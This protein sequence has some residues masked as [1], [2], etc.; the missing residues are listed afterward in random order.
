MNHRLHS[1]VPA[2]CVL[3]VATCLTVAPS[4]SG[5]ETGATAAVEWPAVTQSAKPWTRWWWHGSAVDKEN[6]TRL[7]EEYHAAG[8]GGVEITCI[9]GVKGNEEHNLVFRSPEWVESVQHAIAE[10]TRLGMGVDM[11]SVS[12]WR[13]GGPEVTM[14]DADLKLVLEKSDVAA[15][16]ELDKRFGKTTPQAVVAVADNGKRLDLTDKLVGDSL[17]WEPPANSSWTVYTLGY[18]W[19]GDRVKRPG[20][21]GAGLCINPFSKEAIG[22]YLA[23][24]GKTLDQLPGLRAQTHDSFEYEGN[25]Q[26]SFLAEFERRRGYRLQD[27]LP[28]L[29]GDGPDDLV[30]RVKHDYRETMSDLV[31]ED[32]TEV[33]VEWS[34]G[35][36]CLARDQAHGSPANILDVYAA[37]DIPE[38]ESF[39][40]L[41]GGDTNP[42]V[43]KFASSAANVAG[44]EFASSETGTWLDEHFT[45]TL[46]ELKEI[47]DRQILAG[48]NHVHYH[49]T[50]YSPED[51]A[52]PGWVFYASTQ[53]N[54]QNPIWRDL[55]ALNAYITRCQSVLQASRP[56]N[57]VLLYWPIHDTWQRKDGLRMDIRVHNAHDWLFGHP[58]GDAAVLL[59]KNGYAFDF[60]SDRGLASCSVEAEGKILSPGGTY[61]AIVIPQ[62]QTMPLATLEK[63]ADLAE[64]G[65]T[66]VF[67]G[68]TP[69]GEPGMK[70][71][72]RNPRWDAA[73]KK[74]NSNLGDRMPLVQDLR[75]AGVRCEKSL[76]DLG[77]GFLRK[78]WD[79]DTVYFLKNQ[80]DRAIDDW[81][82]LQSSFTTAVLMDP[83]SGEVGGAETRADGSVRL[84]LAP[85]Q[86]VIL[87]CSQGQPAASPWPYRSVAGDAVELPGPWKV[88]FVTGGPVLPQSFESPK[89]ASWTEVPDTEAQRFAGTARY[90]TTFDAV[91]GTGPQLLDLGA[92]HGSARVSLNG[93]HVA[94]LFTPPYT[95]V[96]SN[97]KPTGNL[98][99][100][101]VTGVAANRVRDLD[102]RGVE[103]RIFEDINFVGIGYKPFDASRWPVRPQGLVGPMTL[104]P[105]VFIDGVPD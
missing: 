44:R 54:P 71:V 37:C 56:D 98:L 48:I 49:G 88:E 2:L 89:P 76:N 72:V 29:A 20:P 30:A 9:Y 96:L 102:R 24:Y 27:H 18:K 86:S 69:R 101:E 73:M 23:T 8:L 11:P 35:H 10:A 13:T 61:N 83:V 95:V 85:G 16:Q 64:A 93:E 50:A 3:Y 47:V 1:C 84:Q 63:L 104:T 28:E 60:I 4:A 77:L 38:T 43:M 74:L 70:G 62:T 90:T 51:A 31:L 46:A 58:L 105:Q 55:P 26:P 40:Q 15:G 92:V 82:T 25:W 91:A 68:N 42:M 19:A 79:G 80:S 75:R 5:A 52:W 59:E 99:D 57:D 7:L 87:R 67:A 81:V 34:H 41:R 45:V 97:L 100:I 103:W 14:A 6:L 66:V 65:S 33:W 78:K 17:H 22:N 94:T 12:G 21:G 32:L 53:V 39:G 36:G